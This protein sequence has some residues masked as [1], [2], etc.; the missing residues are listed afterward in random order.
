[1]A[2]S[3][4]DKKNVTLLST[5]HDNATV[6]KRVRSRQGAEGF[7]NVVKPACVDDYNAHMGGVDRCDQLLSYYEWPHKHQKWFLTIFHRLLEISL[8]NAFIIHHEFEVRRGV[9]T[10]MR[11]KA[12]RE[13]VVQ[14]LIAAVEWPV[15]DRV[16]R[17]TAAISTSASSKTKRT[18]FCGRS[19]QWIIARQHCSL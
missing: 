3:W 15:G 7:R 18:A 5:I 12:F 10:P 6:S 1:M 9:D 14:G 11:L 19:S 8:V 13:S 4:M 16:T 17:S 2:I